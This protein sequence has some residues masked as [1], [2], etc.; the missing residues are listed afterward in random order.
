MAIDVVVQ[1]D[2]RVDVM[3]KLRVHS[4]L[5]ALAE[6]SIGQAIERSRLVSFSDCLDG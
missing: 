2:T 3:D 5:I 6:S 4:Q 1:P